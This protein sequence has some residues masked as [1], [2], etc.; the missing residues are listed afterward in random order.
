MPRDASQ[1]F[2]KNI[3]NLL[4][5]V[6]DG[7]GNWNVDLEDDILIDTVI[8]HNKEIINS[9]VKENMTQTA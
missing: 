9:R 5:L 7:E 4:K 3:M 1:M 8:T 6:I 2:S